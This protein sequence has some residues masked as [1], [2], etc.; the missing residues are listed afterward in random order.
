M[1][2]QLKV[3]RATYYPPTS[4]FKIPK[5]ID[6]EDK[7]VVKGYWVRYDELY[8]EFVDP[9]KDMLRIQPH[10]AASE[11]EDYKDP[12][13]IEV[14]DADEEGISDDEEDEE[15]EEHGI[16][17]ECEKPTINIEDKLCHCCYHKTCDESECYCVNK[18]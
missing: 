8:I 16:C 1:T 5:S 10:L 12:M 6:I 17:D 13:T 4:V 9:S 7:S 18:K 15:E 14:I 2:T 11:S 3:V